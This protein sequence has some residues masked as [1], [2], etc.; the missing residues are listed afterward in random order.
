MSFSVIF[1]TVNYLF[2]ILLYITFANNERFNTLLGCTL[3]LV[4]TMF[5]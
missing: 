5:A 1:L 4:E 2:A 3:A